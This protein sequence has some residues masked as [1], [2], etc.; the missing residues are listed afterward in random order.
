ML[1]IIVL[2]VCEL[3]V[4]FLLFVMMMWRRK[5]INL[6]IPCPCWSLSSPRLCWSLQT[7]QASRDMYYLGFKPHRYW[8]AARGSTHSREVINQPGVL[9][10]PAEQ[11][12]MGSPPRARRRAHR[13]PYKSRALELCARPSWGVTRRGYI[14]ELAGARILELAGCALHQL[15]VMCSSGEPLWVSSVQTGRDVLNQ[16]SGTGSIDC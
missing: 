1:N 14:L 16:K 5:E 3:L 10:P 7:E 11:G 8:V 9:T 13:R 12:L 4:I 15:E 2:N 6:L